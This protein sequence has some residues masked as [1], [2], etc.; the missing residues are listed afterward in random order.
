M[1]QRR[2][3]PT[4]ACSRRRQDNA[5]SLECSYAAC[6]R[7]LKTPTCAV[8]GSWRSTRASPP[9]ASAKKNCASTCST[10]RTTSRCLPAH[11]RSGCAASRSSTSGRSGGSG[12]R[13]RVLR[14]RVGGSQARTPPARRVQRG[15]SAAH[16]GLPPS[17][18]LP[19]LPGHDLHVRFAPARMAGRAGSCTAS[20]PAMASTPQV[21]RSLH[22]PRRH[23]QPAHPESGE[24]PDRHTGRRVAWSGM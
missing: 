19:C 7:R 17:A 4:R 18:P 23:Q 11:S 9:T 8:C 22:L 16:P 24:W 20:R 12:R 5:W 14:V 3:R 13:L 15:R 2:W 6:P 1:F 21:P 10:S